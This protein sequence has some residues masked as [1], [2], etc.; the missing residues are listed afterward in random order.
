MV[1]L[2]TDDE[3]EIAPGCERVGSAGNSLFCTPF[4][5]PSIHHYNALAILETRVQ[6]KCN[7]WMGIRL[8][9][10]LQV[11]VKSKLIEKQNFN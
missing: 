5:R 7:I 4:C 6:V 11:Y 3:D 9:S 10:L 8:I 1:G 2:A